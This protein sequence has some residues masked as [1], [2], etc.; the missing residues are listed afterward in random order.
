MEFDLE[1]VNILNGRILYQTARFVYEDQKTW[2]RRRLFIYNMRF[3]FC[4]TSE[5]L[6]FFVIKYCDTIKLSHT[7]VILSKDDDELN[8]MFASRK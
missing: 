8:S 2:P 4:L 6:Q 5:Q 7:A 3:C 1:Y